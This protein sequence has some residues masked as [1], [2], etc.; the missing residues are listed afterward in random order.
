MTSQ[1]KDISL[2]S[3][4]TL[5]SF[6]VTSLYTNVPVKES[7]QVCADLLFNKMTIEGID[8][9]TFIALAELSCCNV[10]I[11]THRGFFTQIDGL[12]MGSPPAPHLANG[13][14]SQFDEIIKGDSRFYQRYMDDIICSI[15]KAEVENRFQFINNLHPNLSFTLETE[16]NGKIAFL[17][18]IIYNDSGSL[19]SGWYRKQTDTGLTLNYH[20]LAPTKYKKICCN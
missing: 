4:E 11:S 9:E 15:K 5:V 1:I 14:L 8:K 12:A 7:I 17:D 20:S 3:E 2:S 19:S 10:V 16:I 13:W 18:M 6:D